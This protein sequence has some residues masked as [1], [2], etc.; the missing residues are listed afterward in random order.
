MRLSEADHQG[1]GPS[2]GPR[3][4]QGR[5]LGQGTPGSQTESESETQRL[6]SLES[7]PCQVP[8]CRHEVVNTLACEDTHSTDIGHRRGGD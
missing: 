1:P 3:A 5:I 2:M 8:P 7:A 6:A 4:V